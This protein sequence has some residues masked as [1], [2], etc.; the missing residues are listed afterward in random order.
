MITIILSNYVIYY[1]IRNDTKTIKWKE[2]NN[3]K[4]CCDWCL[5]CNFKQVYNT[6]D[7][8]STVLPVL[9]TTNNST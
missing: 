1:I 6:Y 5:Y 9:H 7:I 3:T 2:K 4:N 8:H